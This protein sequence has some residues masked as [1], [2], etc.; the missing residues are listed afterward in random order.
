M[1]TILLSSI[2]L[3]GLTI[4]VMAADLPSRQAPIAAPVFQSVPVFSW[5]GFY[6][7][8]NAGAGFNTGD[9]NSRFFPRGSIIGSEGTSGTL[10]FSDDDEA[11][12]IGGAQIGYNVQFGSFVA[13]LEADL[14]Y[15]NLGNRDNA[16]GGEYTFSPAS[17]TGFGLAF[18][19][20]GATIIGGQAQNPEY[21]ATVRGRLGLAFGQALVY[22]TGGVAFGF[23]D[24]DDFGLNS[25]NDDTSVGY[26]VGAGV[27]YAFTNNLTFKLE[28]LYVNL[29]DDNGRNGDAVYDLATNTLSLNGNGSGDIEFSLVR[30]GANYKF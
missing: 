8:L 11:D 16:R 27:E 24:D 6:V 26:V 17:P 10:S 9:N 29:G 5:T 22:G 13:G 7:G 18:A 3:L 21:F 23:H 15:S 1:K 2:A 20:P 14:Q 30:V 4:G 19:P 28:G 25:G 12:F